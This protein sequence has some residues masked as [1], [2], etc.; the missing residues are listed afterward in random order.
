MPPP[1]PEGP[2]LRTN[3]ATVP[4]P[5]GTPPGAEPAAVPAPPP[6]F[7]LDEAARA[8][9]LVL[10]LPQGPLLVDV[11]IWVD[12]QPYP[13]PLQGAVRQLSDELRQRW[14]PP[15]WDELLDD[16]RLL[17]AL[18]RQAAPAGEERWAL[19]RTV[20]LNDNAL[21]DELEWTTLARRLESMA[22]T[23]ELTSEAVDTRSRRLWWQPLDAD[24]DGRLSP[25]ELARSTE[26][27]A[28]LDAD[29]DETLRRQEADGAASQGEMASLALPEAARVVLLGARVSWDRLYYDLQEMYLSANGWLDA[30]SF[31]LDP[32]LLAVLDHN[33]NGR[34][35]R[36]EL[37]R[38]AHCP[39]HL[40][41]AFC[42][43]EAGP[44][45][46]G[47]SWR[48]IAAPV[49]QAA[50]RTTDQ[51]N[52]LIDLGGA[53]LVIAYDDVMSDDVLAAVAQRLLAAADGNRNGYLEPS[54]VA[55]LGGAVEALA[56]AD[57][58]GDGGLDADELIAALRPRDTIDRWQVRLH[59]ASGGQDVFDWLDADN[60]GR[61]S[62]REIARAGQRL[63]QADGDRDGYV[64]ADE[65]PVRIVLRVQRGGGIESLRGLLD[66]TQWG[67]R[68]SRLA[69]P[70][71]FVGMDANGDG[72]ISRSE[73]LGTAEQF[74]RLDADGD[75]FIDMREAAAAQAGD[76]RSAAQP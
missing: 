2:G 26:A 35:D 25:E 14:P 31:P 50:I 42:L 70:E 43:G 61:L 10:L 5:P 30:E 44:L 28:R 41:L 32:E 73:F 64:A 34:I 74:Q 65:L 17:A 22:A 18:G 68:R 1:S 71:W 19:I 75:G 45:P 69:A 72:D 47:I 58:N 11:W 12:G 21:A 67:P 13:M 63:R 9:R 7:S 66:A 57:L 55:A 24:G 6:S 20:D 40:V 37:P 48:E 62:A 33:G 54:E 29:G 27:L 49:H 8:P 15:A 39:A 46:S 51:Q 16:P 4:V 23:L 53:R 38:L 36:A 76:G 52:L 3:D 60:D 56:E 59:A